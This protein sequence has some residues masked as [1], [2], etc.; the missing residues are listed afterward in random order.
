MSPKSLVTCAIDGCWHRRRRRSPGSPPRRRSAHG[1]N[2]AG[3]RR[4]AHRGPA[5][6]RRGPRG[7]TD[8][9]GANAS[10][11]R[12]SCARA[13]V[14]SSARR[15]SFSSSVFALASSVGRE[16]GAAQ[17][18][19]E[20]VEDHR[21]IA[22]HAV[23]LDADVGRRRH[24][25]SLGADVGEQRADLFLRAR[26]RAARK[27][28]RCE[29]RQ[30]G[31]WPVG[32]HLA[33]HDHTAH[34]HSRHRV[35]LDHVDDEAVGEHASHGACGE[36]HAGGSAAGGPPPAGPGGAVVFFAAAALAA[37]AV[38][39]DSAVAPGTAG[40][41]VARRQRLAVRASWP[42]RTSPPSRDRARGRSPRRA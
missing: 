36:R 6:R 2:R 12:R 32:L 29:R 41:S 28:L 38:A 21:Q 42:A 9:F 26:R 40:G 5:V 4:R 25:A 39:A 33:R 35:V 20:N 27:H 23:G 31:A 30:A 14:L 15:N 8:G 17:L 10:W 7:S 22:R 16:G 19:G 11:A 3:R 1:G 24:V 34:G 37:G 13:D 18:V